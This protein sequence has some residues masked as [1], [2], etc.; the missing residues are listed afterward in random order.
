ML[1]RLLPALCLC[2]AMAPAW[3]QS[4]TAPAATQSETAAPELQTVQISGQRPGPGLWK[5]STGEHVLWIFGTYSPL[6]EKMEWRSQQVESI[7]AQSQEY[8]GIPRVSIGVGF[9]RGLTLLPFLAG[10][11]NNPDGAKLKD[12][13]PAETYARWL[14]LKEKYIGDDD[15]IERQRPFFAA[16]TL[17][18]KGLSRAGLANGTDVVTKSIDKLAKQH[19]V[20]F[21]SMELELEMQDPVKTVREFKKSPMDDAACFARTLDRLETDIVTMRAR[22]AAWAIGDMD[23]IRKLDFNNV[24][25]ACKEAVFGAGGLRDQAALKESEQRQ[26]TKWLAAADKALAANSSTFALLSMRELMNPKGLLADLQ[27]KGYTVQAPE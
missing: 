14:A 10:V 23:V 27:A 1:K 18:R 21:T 12:V 2:A 4:D 26:R 11:Q 9:F 8:I 13:L 24:E 15:G 6:P 7:L 5:V 20:K 17:M 19:N 25:Q 16:E 22:A 3:S